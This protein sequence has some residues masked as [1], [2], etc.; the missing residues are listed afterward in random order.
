M[1]SAG[2]FDRRVETGVQRG[3]VRV[4][5]FASIIGDCDK[6]SASVFVIRQQCAADDPRWTADHRER[7]AADVAVDQCADDD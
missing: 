5:A 4:G 2:S 3:A 7:V 1:H 6:S